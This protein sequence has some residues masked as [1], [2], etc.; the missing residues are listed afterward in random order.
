MSKEYRLREMKKEDYDLVYELLSSTMGVCVRTNETPGALAMFLER[1]PGLSTVA[2]SGEKVVGCIMAG[3]DGR[4]GYL[5][6]L[7]V[8]SQWR[9]QGIGTV[10]VSQTVVKLAF[11]GITRYHLDLLPDNGPGRLF[12]E[13]LGWVRRMDIERFT[14]DLMS[15]KDHSENHQFAA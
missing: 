15:H 12:W 7:A 3:H 9:R 5:T 4:R 13:S 6:H 1:N 8:D 14:F 11:A 2:V 10:L